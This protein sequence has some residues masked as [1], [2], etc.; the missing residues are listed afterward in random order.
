MKNA[1]L[2]IKD[3]KKFSDD[4][5]QYENDF[6][7]EQ[8]KM[9]IDNFADNLQDIY[10]WLEESE[11]FDDVDFPFA[12]YVLGDTINML[13]NIAIKVKGETK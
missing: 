1:K 4:I 6:D 10:D 2:V 3:S 5:W 12:Q 13:R 7:S 11:L 9:A 8:W